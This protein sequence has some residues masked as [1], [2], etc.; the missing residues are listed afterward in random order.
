VSRK[1][2]SI[3]VVDDEPD[4][5]ANLKDILS[6]FGYQVDTATAGFEA[7]KLLETNRYDVALLDLKMPGMSGVDLYREIKRRSSST[8]GLIISA[9]ASTTSAAEAL[10][11]GAWKVLSKPVNATQVMSCIDEAICQPLVMI[12]DDD[13]ELCASLWDVLHSQGIRV[14]L[15]HDLADASR[16]L[17]NPDFQ[18]A[19]VDLK[20]PQGNG[21]QFC[22]ELRQKHPQ[23]KTIL[24]T[25]YPNEL[26]ER[27]GDRSV[28]ATC[29]KPFDV[30][31]LIGMLRRLTAKLQVSSEG[32]APQ[33]TL[34]S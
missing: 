2:P 17:I 23:V 30:A 13:Q 10:E 8:V 18:A 7:L 26:E 27:E 14:E 20:F 22:G 24:I 31:E 33:S 19:I 32:L 5:C 9:Y 28:D 11:A 6:E 34:R 16:I 3:L 12:V 15:A 1:S 29:Y 25:G 4:I 21:L